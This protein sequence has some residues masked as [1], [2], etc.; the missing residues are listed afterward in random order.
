M[1]EF[2]NMPLLECA[3]NTIT[4]PISAGLSC[5]IIHLLLAAA[6]PGCTG[7]AAGNSAA[8]GRWRSVGQATPLVVPADQA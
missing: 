8:K 5:S 4:E 7:P 3:W 6:S 2:P 1:L